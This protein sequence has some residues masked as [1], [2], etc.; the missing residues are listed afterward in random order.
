MIWRPYAWQTLRLLVGCAISFALSKLFHLQEAYWALI[1]TVVVTQPA[2]NETITASIN[3]V[4]GTIIGAAIGFLVLEAATPSLPAAW[5][6]W[7]A[8]LPLAI[9]TSMRQSLRLSCITLIVVVLIPSTGPVFT[10]PLD[11]VIGIL[12]GTAAALVVA[13]VLRWSP[14]GTKTD[15]PSS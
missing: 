4:M 11:R 8:L 7:P 14:N 13:V 6:F 5:L 2:L 12:L 1:T 9:L 10:R 15:E 3:R